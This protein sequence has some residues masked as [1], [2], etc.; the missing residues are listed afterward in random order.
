MVN[1]GDKVK[2]TLSGFT[3]VAVSSHHYLHGCTRITVQPEVK[4]DGTLPETQTFDEPQL[5]VVVTEAVRQGSRKNGGPS[6][7]EDDGR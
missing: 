7:Y 2:D 4:E 3:G 6:R 5:E 1:L